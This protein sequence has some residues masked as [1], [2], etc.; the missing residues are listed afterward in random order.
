[1]RNSP[2][3]RFVLAAKKEG[4]FKALQK[5]YGWIF[6]K[7]GVR[8]RDP[9]YARRLKISNKLSEMY[10]ST[11]VNG[12][13]R[14]FKIPRESWWGAA[15][16]GSMLLGLYEK[17][18]LESLASTPKQYSQFI[19]LGAADGYYGV[20]VLVSE[21]FQKSVCYEMSKQGREAILRSA[22]LN[23]VS[24]NIDIR[25][26]A[27][28]KF[29]ED[30]SQES[31]SNSVLFIDIEGAEFDL[32][33]EKMFNAFSNSIIY[34]ELHDWFF[35]DGDQKLSKLKLNSIKTHTITELKMG[36]RD[37]SAFPDLRE[38]NDDD[39]WLICSEGRGQLMTWL[40]FNPI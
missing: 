5:T 33:D 9:I 30:F 14:G 27:T 39:R 38:F 6:H 26:L 29:Y 15:D 31:L 24:D 16:R 12:P 34:V 40:R 20:G 10:D 17:E 21:L 8:R 3:Y 22:R 2:L 35:V 23:D 28:Q 32:L 25:G 4:L 7:L 37:P 1:M 13:F 19:D 36:S 18:I 11:V